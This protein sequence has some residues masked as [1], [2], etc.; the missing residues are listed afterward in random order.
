M[1]V[2]A[3]GLLEGFRGAAA[4][5]PG[6]EHGALSATTSGRCAQATRRDGAR[7]AQIGDAPG[8]KS[9]PKYKFKRDGSY[10]P[11]YPSYW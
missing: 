11:A 2:P 5:V 10:Y 1:G 4:Y 7:T 6:G 3:G 8:K 9:W